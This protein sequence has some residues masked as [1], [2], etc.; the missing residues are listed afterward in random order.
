MTPAPLVEEY[1]M[2][3]ISDYA[4]YLSVVMINGVIGRTTEIGSGVCIETVGE[5][6]RGPAGIQDIKEAS[7][8]FR[9]ALNLA[10]ERGDEHA[11]YFK[12]ILADYEANGI[13]MPME[14]PFIE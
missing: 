6:Q 2:E 13:C 1:N 11:D 10:I 7:P 14:E 3:D 8:I 12:A 5:L 4:G 9:K